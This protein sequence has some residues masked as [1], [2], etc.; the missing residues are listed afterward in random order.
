MKTT[1]ILK[2]LN[3]IEKEF[4]VDTWQVEG[5]EI[6]PLIRTKIHFALLQENKIESKSGLWD[7]IKVLLKEIFFTLYIKFKDRRQNEAIHNADVIFL[8]D[9]L[10]RNFEFLNLG[11]YDHNLDSVRVEMK[12]KGIKTYSM[13]VLSPHTKVNFPRYTKSLIINHSLIL[14]KV[15][16][17]FSHFINKAT[18]IS[19]DNYDEFVNVCKESNVKISLDIELIYKEVMYI[20]LLVEYFK[21]RIKTSNAKLGIL[22][23]WYGTVGMAFCMACNQMKIECVDIQHGIAGA[24]DHVQYSKWEKIPKNNYYNCMPSCFW[25]WSVE[26]AN[27]INAWNDGKNNLNTIVGGKTINLLWKNQSSEIV[28]YYQKK[29]DEIFD[30]KRSLILLTLQPIVEYP[31]WLVELIKESK[32]YL[33]WGI[34][35]HPTINE[36]QKKFIRRIECLENV[37]WKDTT[38]IPLEILLQNV[39]VH[40]TGFSSVILDAEEF[41]VKSIMLDKLSRERFMLQFKRGNLILAESKEELINSI[42][43]CLKKEKLVINHKYLTDPMDE[44]E[45]LIKMDDDNG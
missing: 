4:P 7:K 29:F 25:C 44:L 2:F 16:K 24:S 19:L 12:K 15:K 26:D 27:A 39:D 30:K 32:N 17:F 6:W 23:C 42:R 40:I 21:Q 28:R 33:Y 45:K 36:K 41:G 31:E 20:N 43:T 35:Q 5:V 37:N 9:N 8:S 3:K 34:R 13:E 10:D 22:Q 18:Q 14:S 38:K 1:E 11:W